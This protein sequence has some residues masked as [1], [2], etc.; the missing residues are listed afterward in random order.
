M[1]H[2]IGFCVTYRLLGNIKVCLLNDD[3]V[4]Y[5]LHILRKNKDRV[6]L[7]TVITH[8]TGYEPIVCLGIFMYSVISSVDHNIL[9]FD[10]IFRKFIY[11]TKAKLQNKLTYQK[12]T[13]EDDYIALKSKYVCTYISRVS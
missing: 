7:K 11:M 8:V 13:D 4:V 6:V 1:C 2:K 10:T 9:R 5:C 3:F 12:V